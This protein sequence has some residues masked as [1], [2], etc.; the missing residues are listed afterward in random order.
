NRQLFIKREAD[1]KAGA[2]RIAWVELNDPCR[3]DHCVG[4]N[5]LVQL[6]ARIEEDDGGIALQDE[7]DAR[8]KSPVARAC[9]ELPLYARSRISLDVIG[10]DA[11]RRFDPEIGDRIRPV[12]AIIELIVNAE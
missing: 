3:T 6:I 11:S 9:R 4:V 1:P 2:D 12:A 8:L 7:G 10:A 5:R